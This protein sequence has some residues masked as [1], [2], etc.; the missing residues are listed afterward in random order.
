VPRFLVVRLSLLLSLVL[1]APAARAAEAPPSES[2]TAAALRGHVFFLAADA[3]GGR[4]VNSR[5]FEV[6]AQYA[7][8]QF[9]AAGV[10]SLFED[11]TG[12]PF[13]QDV[14]VS[15]RTVSGPVSLIVTNAKGAQVFPEGQDVKWFQGEIYPMEHRALPLVYV[16]YGISE[17][18][19][20][21]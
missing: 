11:S 6:A 19:R 5:G 13:R 16:G 7:E 8:S 12:S 1:V 14:P 2:I 3:L 21:G 18:E 10:L 15:R 17:P 20:V 9:R 4:P